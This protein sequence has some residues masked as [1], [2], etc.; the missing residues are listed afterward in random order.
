VKSRLLRS[1]QTA[2]ICGAFTAFCHAGTVSLYFFTRRCRSRRAVHL[3][4]DAVGRGRLGDARC[5]PTPAERAST[6]TAIPEGRPWKASS[7]EGRG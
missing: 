2:C 6:T 1:L 7:F 3:R 4:P 5:R